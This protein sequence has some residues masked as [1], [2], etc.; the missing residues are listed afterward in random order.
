MA[1]YVRPTSFHTDLSLRLQVHGSRRGYIAFN[2]D[3]YTQVQ[4]LDYLLERL[5]SETRGKKFSA[6]NRAIAELVEEYGLV[7]FHTLAVE[8]RPLPS[9][10]KEKLHQQRS[11]TFLQRQLHRTRPPWLD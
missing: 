4:D 8:V 9:S 10:R 3:Y 5:E 1:P 11:L 7:S 2:L 6:L